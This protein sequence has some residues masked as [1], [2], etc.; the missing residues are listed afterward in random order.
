MSTF[1]VSVHNCVDIMSIKITF[2][3]N[4]DQNLFR[5]D[6]GTIKCVFSIDLG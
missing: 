5:Y 3:A 1:I 6:L 2:K 4:T